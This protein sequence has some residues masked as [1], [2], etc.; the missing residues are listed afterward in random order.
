[1]TR[2]PLSLLLAAPLAAGAQGPVR[3]DA[4]PAAAAGPGTTAPAIA[5][6]DLRARLAAFAHDSLAG[7]AAG[8]EAHRRATA[9]IAGELRRLGLR[10]AGDSGTFLQ[11]LPFVRYRIAE[12]T[13]LTLGDSTYE[14]YDD[15]FAQ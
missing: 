8:T 11:A 4:S 14:P 3:K 10:P 9:Y 13:R 5:E 15:F 12:G 1:M 2:L 6:A 7:R